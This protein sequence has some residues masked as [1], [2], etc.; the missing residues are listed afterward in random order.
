[1][2]QSYAYR[3]LDQGRVIREI[4]SAAGVSPMGDIGLSEREARD[5]KPRLALVVDR[6]REELAEVPAER[7][8]EVVREV[9]AEERERIAQ[10][11]EDRRKPPGPSTHPGAAVMLGP[12]RIKDASVW[13]SSSST[14]VCRWYSPAAGPSWWSVSRW[15]ASLAK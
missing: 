13:R 4:E 1:M 2:S 3:L 7:A 9:V 6:V 8:A 11:R 14:P 15:S 10:Q 12:Q 5:L